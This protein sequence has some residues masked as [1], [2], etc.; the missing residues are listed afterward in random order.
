MSAQSWRAGGGQPPSAPGTSAK[1]GRS[2]ISSTL[3]EPRG[4]PRPP[5]GSGR[6]YAVLTPDIGLTLARGRRRG[7]WHAY[8]HTADGRVGQTEVNTKEL[9]DYEVFRMRAM[10]AAGLPLPSMTWEQWREILNTAMNIL[11]WEEP[12]L[13]P[14]WRAA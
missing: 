12:E 10:L 8:L 2:P 7:I 1:E 3:P 11:R 13:P 6:V 5:V 14:E 9:N 4:A